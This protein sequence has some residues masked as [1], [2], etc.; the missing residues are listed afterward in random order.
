MNGYR[1]GKSV[2]QDR[3]VAQVSGQMKDCGARVGVLSVKAGVIG[4]AIEV[5]QRS[6]RRG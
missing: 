5:A 3:T 6:D 1:I 4:A 2:P